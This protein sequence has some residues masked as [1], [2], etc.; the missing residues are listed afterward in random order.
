MM[1]GVFRKDDWTFVLLYKDGQPMVVTTHLQE[2]KP[3]AD[4]HQLQPPFVRLDGNN[5]ENI[6]RYI[7][8]IVPSDNP[9]LCKPRNFIP[10]LELCVTNMNPG[11]DKDI[12][13]TYHSRLDQ[14][15][16]AA[17][18]DTLTYLEWTWLVR[19]I[20]Q[21]YFDARREG[22]ELVPRTLTNFTR[23]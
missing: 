16:N 15:A 17:D 8:G 13:E 6:K 14:H 4:V 22:S 3:L 5:D 18:D 19:E 10:I 20:L 7:M 9:N 21:G 12:L 11:R 23:R 2:M 1:A